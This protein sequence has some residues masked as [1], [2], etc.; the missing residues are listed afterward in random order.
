MGKESGHVQ[1]RRAFATFAVNGKIYAIG[2]LTVVD[3]RGKKIEPTLQ[4]VE[5]YDP[6]A[7][8]WEAKAA[9]ALE[10]MNHISA[11]VLA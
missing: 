3:R 8:A 2:G 4:T 1:V 11:A 7:N 10:K 6:V 5:A 9:K